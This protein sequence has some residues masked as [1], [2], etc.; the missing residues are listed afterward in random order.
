MVS[1][2]T[3]NNSLTP[4][5]PTDPIYSNQAGAIIPQILVGGRAPSSI[6]P[7]SRGLIRDINSSGRTPNYQCMASRNGDVCK[8]ANGNL[9][10]YNNSRD[11]SSGCLSAQAQVPDGCALVE[12]GI[13][14]SPEDVL[15]VG[16]NRDVCTR[17]QI[18][19]NNKKNSCN[20]LIRGNDYG[21]FK[22][23]WIEERP[24]Q[25]IADSPRPD[26]ICSGRSG[27]ACRGPMAGCAWYAVPS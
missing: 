11:R 5:P 26:L 17:S 15:Y 20:E 3:Q 7:T 23:E 22:C 27:S 4:T 21:T 1:P 14:V 13:C 25:C 6:I 12:Y 18:D 19:A 24:E 10:Y 8:K 2:G 16:T 9:F